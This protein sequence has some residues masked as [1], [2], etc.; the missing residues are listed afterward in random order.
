MT[1][2]TASTIRPVSILLIEDNPADALLATEALQAA[3]VPTSVSVLDNAEAA[4]AW[5]R[6]G[7]RPELIIL[8]LNLPGMTGL[9]LLDVLKRDHVLRAIPVIVLTTSSN[10]V[11]VRASYDRFANSYVTKSLRFDEFEA[12]M[13]SIDEFWLTTAELPS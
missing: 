4:L 3:T 1:T 2:T 13:R 11:D 7:H 5:L 10:S 6:S 9:E 12:T 8:D